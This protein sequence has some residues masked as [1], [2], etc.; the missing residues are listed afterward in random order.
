MSLFPFVVTSSF[1]WDGDVLVHIEESVVLRKAVDCLRKNRIL[2]ESD[3]KLPSVV[4][5]VAGKSIQ[6]SWWGHPL[7]HTIW[8]VVRRLN[9]HRDVL[10]TKLVSGK[11]TF[12]DRSIWAD[13]IAV[14]ASR[15]QWQMT[16]LSSH[17]RF[18]LKLLDEQR[19]IRTDEI[20]WP[21]RLNLRRSKK[22]LTAGDATRELETKI[23]VQSKEVHT[24]S[25]AHAKRLRT[26]EEWRRRVKFHHELVPP[27][28]GM[29]KLEELLS[30]LNRKYHAN[31]KL[32][33]N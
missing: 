27:E 23:L 24:K 3:P 17:A 11:V 22:T 26:W 33:W 1:V 4:G 18:L 31:G 16:S 13:V 9:S 28:E 21:S 15:Q 30:S 19:Q 20:K 12:V 7:S 14:G 8:A 32:P 5:M 6:G 10:V 2:L 29:T 25:G